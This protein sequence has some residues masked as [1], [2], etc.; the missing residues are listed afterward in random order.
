MEQEFE[1]TFRANWKQVSER[2]GNVCVSSSIRSCPQVIAVTKTHPV[3]MVRLA[4]K[5]GLNHIGESRVQEAEKKFEQLSGEIYTRHLIGHLQ[6]NKANKAAALFDWIQSMDSQML[7]EKLS[8]KAVELGKK[9]QV[10]IEVNTSGESAKSGVREE[11]AG[12]LA[13][14][15]LELP[16]L[17]LRGL[18]TIGPVTIE[19]KAT[20]E[21]FRSLYR[22]RESLRREYPSTD[23][24]TLSMGMSSDFEW[25]IEEGSTMLRLGSILFGERV[26][27]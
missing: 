4:L 15:I 8:R 5:Y 24:D 2:I 17:N 20:R 14:K 21:A 22:L 3:E 7:A 23:L 6:E 12:E 11:E 1:S 16:G 19:E 26:Y 10:L 13:G 25:A 27:F 9:L 18:M